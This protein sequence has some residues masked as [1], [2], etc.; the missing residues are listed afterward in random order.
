M[1]D[2]DL[3]SIKMKV[4]D[5]VLTEINDLDNI[6]EIELSKKSLDN[7]DSN[8]LKN[9]IRET[10]NELN[11]FKKNNSDKDITTLEKIYNKYN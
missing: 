9:I 8:E 3:K 2:D 10:M 1:L 7:L 6:D 11:E 4:N 5:K